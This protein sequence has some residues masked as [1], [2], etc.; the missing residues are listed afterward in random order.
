MKMGQHLVAFHWLL[1]V[2][3]KVSGAYRRLTL[4]SGK[5]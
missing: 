4:A 3:G 5:E 1:F 2:M